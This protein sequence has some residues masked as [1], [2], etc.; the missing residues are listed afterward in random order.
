MVPR[1]GAEIFKAAALHPNTKPLAQ[2][3]WR[4]RDSLIPQ[5]LTGLPLMHVP[6]EK[7]AAQ[8]KRPSV[9]DQAPGFRS[10][11]KY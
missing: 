10:Q 8:M 4:L 2:V 3:P 6:S 7:F 9:A 11:C 5:K 1:A